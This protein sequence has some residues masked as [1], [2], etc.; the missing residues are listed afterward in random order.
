M[1]PSLH[2]FGHQYIKSD[3]TQ[4]GLAKRKT[5]P[6]IGRLPKNQHYIKAD[7]AYMLTVNWIHT[8]KIIKSPIV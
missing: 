7:L 5:V 6:E 3:G 1:H 8:R 2:S 4:K